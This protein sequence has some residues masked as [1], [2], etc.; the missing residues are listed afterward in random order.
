ME[1]NTT[2]KESYPN[3]RKLLWQTMETI[4]MITTTILERNKQGT[5]T[6][7]ISTMTNTTKT[8]HSDDGDGVG[9]MVMVLE[10]LIKVVLV[11]TNNLQINI[12]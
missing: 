3:N 12:W 9:R 6:R 11:G 2:T 7:N 8:K 10:Q 1:S 5:K 4:T